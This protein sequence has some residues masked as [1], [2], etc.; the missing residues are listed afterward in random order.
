MAWE[1][2][3]VYTHKSKRNFVSSFFDGFTNISH[4]KSAVIVYCMRM[5]DTKFSNHEKQN[6]DNFVYWF[7]IISHPAPVVQSFCHKHNEKHM[8]VHN[9]RA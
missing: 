8:A 4:K 6:N 2:G 5:D 1:R 7:S 9:P 3:Y